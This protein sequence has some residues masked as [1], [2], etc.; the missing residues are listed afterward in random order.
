MR[1]TD[2]GRRWAR[3]AEFARFLVAGAGTTLASYG[4]Y[5]L[6][7]PRWPYPVAYTVSY[8]F[9]LVVS[10]AFA[11]GFVFRSRVAARS[12]VRFPLVY[13]AQYVVGLG[14]LTLLIGLGVPPRVAPLA[15]V[16]CTIP[17]TFVLSARV[18]RGSAPSAA[19]APS[20]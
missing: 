7:L 4:V 8:L 17:L 16:A 18:V 11:C 3:A 15:V 14:T 9:G 10:Y 2:G 13:A 20:R 12:A 6:L 1:S 5:L 19:A